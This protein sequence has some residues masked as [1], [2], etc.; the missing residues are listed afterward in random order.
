MCHGCAPSKTEI[1]NVVTV[2]QGVWARRHKQ[3]NCRDINS[4]AIYGT[5]MFKVK[6]EV[7]A[8]VGRCGELS[9]VSRVGGILVRP[10]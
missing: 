3:L 4:G 1:M 2:I 9:V 8:S 7:P 10:L 6:R 5:D